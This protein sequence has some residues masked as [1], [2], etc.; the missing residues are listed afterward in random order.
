MR[1]FVYLLVMALLAA[2]V[3]FVVGKKNAPA[4]EAA[5][6]EGLP[7]ESAEQSATPTEEGATAETAV[8]GE[9][10]ANSVPSNFG[11]LSDFTLT[12]QAGQDFHM[13]SMKGKVL[14]VNFFF[15]RCEGP[16]PMMN[17]KMEAFQSTFADDANIHL[18]SITVDPANDNVEALKT[19]ASKFNAKVEKWSFLTGS[20]DVITTIM[21]KEMKLGGAEDIQSH[22]TRLVLIDKDGTIK[23]FY[24]S[25]SEEELVKAEK[26]ARQ[27]AA[28]VS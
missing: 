24:D 14:L 5:P 4:P 18:V 6:A 11:K 19:Y 7:A 27:L 10:A 28:S 1:K 9:H 26:D 13:S 17:K 23:G 15:T 20:K 12:D 2:G 3:Y 22:S 25:A 21:E 8:D 16:C